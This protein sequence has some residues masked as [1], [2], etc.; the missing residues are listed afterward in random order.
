MREAMNLPKVGLQNVT[1]HYASESKTHEKTTASILKDIII[2]LFLL[3]ICNSKQYAH[4]FS[5]SDLRSTS[6]SVKQI[7]IQTIAILYLF[8]IE[9]NT[10]SNKYK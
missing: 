9:F 4:Q 10:S 7:T 1:R 8:S 5:V 6:S 2:S 3:C